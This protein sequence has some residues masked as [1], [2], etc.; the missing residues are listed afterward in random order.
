MSACTV[1]GVS[2]VLQASTLLA[3]NAG[4]NPRRTLRRMAIRASSIPK[5]KV[6]AIWEPSRLEL[7]LEKHERAVQYFKRQ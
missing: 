6:G 4:F 7:R 5:P 3:D 2:R 1:A